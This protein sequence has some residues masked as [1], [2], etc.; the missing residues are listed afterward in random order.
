MDFINSYIIISLRGWDT[1][2]IEEFDRQK[3]GTHNYIDDDK[4]ETIDR[5]Y[6]TTMGFYDTMN[7]F[8]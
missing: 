2:V 8:S 5:A 4:N 3:I 6:R 1:S 7:Y